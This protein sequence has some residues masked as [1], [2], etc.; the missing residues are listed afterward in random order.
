MSNGGDEYRRFPRVLTRCRVRI[1]DR[2]GV[3]DA[4]TEDVGPRGCRIVTLRPQTVGALV[5]LTLESERVPEPLEVTGQIVWARA[6]RPARAGISFA[7]GTSSPGAIAPGPW[8]ET[9]LA[10][11]R[12][13]HPS[14]LPGPEI[15][16][17]IDG[18]EHAPDPLVERLVHRAEQ[19]LGG[20]ERA[21]AELIFR[22]ALA[23]APGDA[24]LETTLRE[25]AAR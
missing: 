7:G 20:G 5:S 15:V 14:G 1:R 16:I 23:L 25:L 13:A 24:A 21:A 18:P 17:Q 3:W 9:I 11:E 4:E 22:R 10:A 19:L 6:D 8:F 2:F 12:A